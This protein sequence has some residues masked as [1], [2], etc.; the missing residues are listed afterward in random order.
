MIDGQVQVF[1]PTLSE[2][3]KGQG[4]AP[5]RLVTTLSESMRWPNRLRWRAGEASEMLF[6]VTSRRVV[7]V[8]CGELC[9]DTNRDSIHHHE[10]EGKVMQTRESLLEADNRRSRQQERC[11]EHRLA[12]VCRSTS[13]A[14]C[15]HACFAHVF[16]LWDMRYGMQ[17]ASST[18]RADDAT[19]WHP[20]KRMIGAMQ[21]H[22]ATCFCAGNTPLIRMVQ[23]RVEQSAA[24]DGRCRA[25]T[26][27]TTRA[28]MSR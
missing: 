25:A 26:Q 11:T 9:Q 23:R 17:P 18:I 4:A 1:S 19:D 27:S 15:A 20:N 12:T 2:N 3:D 24:S 22:I 6:V 13:A 16:I 28:Q 8:N 7:Q 14:A 21:R 5:S 10:P